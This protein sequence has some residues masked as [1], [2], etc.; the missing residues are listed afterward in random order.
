MKKYILA[1]D[2]GTTGSRAIVYDKFGKKIASAYHEFPQH[3]PEPG[4]VEHNPLDIWRTVNNSIQ[5][6]LKI[7]S[8]NSIQAIGITNQRETTVIWDKNT[9]KPIYNAIVW[10]CHRTSTRCE[11][12]KK[13]K[14][15]VTKIKQKTG[16]KVDAYFSATKI[17]WILK[18]VSGARK[19]ALAGELL[20]GTIDTWLLWKLTGGKVHATDYTNA[21]RTLLFN[22]EKLAWDPYLLKLFNIPI[23]ILPKVHAS[24]H[25]F[26]YTVKVGLL[27]AHIPISGIAGDQQAGLFGQTCFET[28]TVNCTYGTGGFVLFN[29]GKKK[30]NSRHGLLTTLGCDAKGQPAYLL[31]GGV[32]I[33]G[34]AIQWLRDGL[35]I[36]KH[37]SHSEKM[38]TSIKDN[39]GVYF[40]PA[41]V[42]LGAPYW[43]QNVRGLITGITR[44]TNRNH[45]V[46]AALEAICYQIKDLFMAMEKDS[47]IDIKFL[48]VDGGAAEN[49]FLCQ[50]QSDILNTK[51]IRPTVIE[52]TSLGAAYLAGL[53]VGY[54]KD[55]EEIKRCWKQDKEFM[56]MMEQKMRNHYYQSWKNAVRKTIL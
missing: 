17:E 29:T 34:A 50:F 21:S 25:V 3:F 22:I 38:A 18:N 32:Y 19:K 49:N 5:K 45:F 56:P 9:G 42:G 14:S 31:E 2:Q 6:V 7:V 43:K 30:V 15:V 13:H 24:S 39:G 52:T 23:K 4:W 46:R 35:N 20:F 40:V 16:L 36:I 54:W 44:G 26:G 41:F 10:Q 33:A 48:K 11:R 12:L 37:A 53:T 8:P 27:P 51:V 28:G 1:I 55:A 47:G